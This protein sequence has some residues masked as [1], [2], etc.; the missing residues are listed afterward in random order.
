M[1]DAKKRAESIERGAALLLQFGMIPTQVRLLKLSRD[2]FKTA[3]AVKA[4]TRNHGFD[5]RGEPVSLRDHFAC[6]VRRAR[7]FESGSLHEVELS[8]AV[9]AE[10]G[11]PIAKV[12]AQ[13]APSEP[14]PT[15]EIALRWTG[16]LFVVK[17]KE[18]D[19][20]DP[21]KEVRAFG[22]VSKPEVPDSEGTVISEEEIE[23]ANDLFM[24]EFQTIGFMH[25]KE[26]TEKVKM[27]QN[28]IAP[29]DI[30]F[31]LPSGATKK[32]S[33][34]T[35]Y[36]QLFTDD[37][38][39]VGK[40]RRGEITGL[41]I[42]G[43]AKKVPLTS[44]RRTI[45]LDPSNPVH[46]AALESYA[47]LLFPGDA[48]VKR[49]I[50]AGEVD[51]IQKRAV[52]ERIA[53]AEGDEATERFVNLRV[54]EVSLVDAAANEEVFFVVK[55]KQPT[56]V[57]KETSNNE[58]A[59]MDPKNLEQPGTPP[60][61]APPAPTTQPPAMQPGQQT[62]AT[63]PPVVTTPPTSPT[64]VTV[65]EFKKL[66]EQ[67]ADQGKV[68]AELQKKQ[69]VEPTAPVPPTP[70][71]PANDEVTKRL[72]DLEAKAKTQEE[73]LEK[74]NKALEQSAITRAAA[75][76]STVPP[77]TVS[78]TTSQKPVSKWAGTAVGIRYGK[79]K[80]KTS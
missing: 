30:E 4:W 63:V 31:P 26:V 75:Q 5:L 20:A 79:D 47:D 21:D 58:G 74:A 32:I 37:E 19:T 12:Q 51:E 56:Q 71:P 38:E 60:A 10:V 41:S 78:P 57:S 50:L 69:T 45:K 40:I 65:E 76:G 39:L 9:L 52:H 22:I 13:D 77:D 1:Q 59:T 3:A 80:N 11:D 27:L 72:A 34:G 43:W 55:R 36:Q 7:E 8:G 54:E 15:E 2:E 14:E 28:V 70:A 49:R 33:K 73:A 67:L 46:R 61:P 64:T 29:V 25:A 18:V 23:Q 35:W 48:E 24:R 53:K 6:E 62:T 66:Q 44:M 68:I 42:G 16:D 17:A